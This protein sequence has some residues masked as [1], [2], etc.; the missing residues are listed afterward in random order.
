MKNYEFE[1]GVLTGL[2]IAAVIAAVVVFLPKKEEPKATW[3]QVVDIMPP[4]I[5][6]DI[7]IDY[8]VAHRRLCRQLPLKSPIEPMDGKTKS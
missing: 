5:K 7:A 8:C 3:Q 2:V 6:R 1:Q 4:S